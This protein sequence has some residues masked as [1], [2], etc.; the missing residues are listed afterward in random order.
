MYS[1]GKEQGGVRTDGASHVKGEANAPVFLP[2]MSVS[3]QVVGMKNSAGCEVTASRESINACGDTLLGLPPH[4][5]EEV[6]GCYPLTYAS[7]ITVATHDCQQ[8]GD[9][10][11]HL[12]I[13][14]FLEWIY[15]TK[16]DQVLDDFGFV[17]LWTHAPEIY[18]QNRCG[19][20]LTSLIQYHPYPAALVGWEGNCRYL[21]KE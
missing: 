9:H 2:T 17:S 18:E 6:M 12:R 11:V 8:I 10:P 15:T 3:L 4:S 5:T 21:D 13:A 16:L 1:I 20:I 19:F 7:T 14:E